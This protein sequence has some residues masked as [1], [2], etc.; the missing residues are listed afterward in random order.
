MNA[1]ALSPVLTANGTA[2]HRQMFLLLRDQITRGTLAPGAALPNEA[3]LCAQFGVS[4]ITVRRAVGDLAA[5]GFVKRVHGKGTYVQA[6][7]VP[8]QAGAALGSL[9]ALVAGGAPTQ[10]EVLSVRHLPPP[11]A[12][13]T[14]LQ[15]PQGE[16]AVQALRLR[17]AGTLAL[18]LIETWLPESLSGK[19]PP[20][21]LKT[22]STERILLDQGLRFGKIVQEVSAELADP[23]RAKL[24]RVEL[25]APLLRL[26][27]L[28]HDSHARPVQHVTAHLCPDRSR[29]V[30]EFSGAAGNGS[31]GGHVVHAAA[32]RRP[33]K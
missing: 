30:S 20:A 23:T 4:R 16:P 29:I 10:V 24:L 9:D 25:G 8:A 28:L 33:R 21:A 3:T 12:I 15:L 14:L 5:Q 17:K 11:P 2:L 27:R 1:Q 26:T 6:V 18:M 32:Q 7:D 22:Q 19:L 13:A 31:G